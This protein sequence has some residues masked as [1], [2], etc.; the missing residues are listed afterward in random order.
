M[1]ENL[2]QITPGAAK[3][4]NIARMGDFVRA[5]PA[6]AAPGHS[7][8]ARSLQVAD[9][10]FGVAPCYEVDSGVQYR[11]RGPTVHR[12]KFPKRKF[13]GEISTWVGWRSL[14][15]SRRWWA[16]THLGQDQLVPVF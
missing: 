13:F 7:C 8:R 11:N 14:R 16:S 10:S 9:G 15:P 5:F 4:V 3:D 1:Q 6:P 2:D 12:A